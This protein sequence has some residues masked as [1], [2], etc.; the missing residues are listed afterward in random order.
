MPIQ[1]KQVTINITTNF[2]YNGSAVLRTEKVGITNFP[3]QTQL[4]MSAEEGGK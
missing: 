1:L 2:L 3:C 4:L